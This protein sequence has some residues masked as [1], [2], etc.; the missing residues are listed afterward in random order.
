[1]A[2]PQNANCDFRFVYFEILKLKME[3]LALNVKDK[4][5]D[6]L[7]LKQQFEEQLQNERQRRFADL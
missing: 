1:M 3:K 5:E 6:V 7:K 2:K 4:N